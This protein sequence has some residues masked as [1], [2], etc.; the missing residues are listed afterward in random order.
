M[1]RTIK[2]RARSKEHCQ[3]YPTQASPLDRHVQTNYSSPTGLEVRAWVER[4]VALRMSY[5]IVIVEFNF[6]LAA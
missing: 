6:L 5:I 4:L 3:Q 2:A 1:I